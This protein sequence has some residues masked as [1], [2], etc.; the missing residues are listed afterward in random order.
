ITAAGGETGDVTLPDAAGTPTAGP[1]GIAQ[2]DAT[3]VAIDATPDATEE[4][5]ASATAFGVG[6]CAAALLLPLAVVVSRGAARR[7]RA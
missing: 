3:P 7:R 2:T 6:P 1:D 4:G 5:T